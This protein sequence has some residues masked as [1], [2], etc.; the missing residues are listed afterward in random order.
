[1]WQIDADGDRGMDLLDG[2]N[3]GVHIREIE[4]FKI[5]IRRSQAT[6]PL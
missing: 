5:L 2:D 4:D 3:A 6:V 1:M